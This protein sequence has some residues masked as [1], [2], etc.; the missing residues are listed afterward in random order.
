MG[1][2]SSY[3]RIRKGRLL[4]GCKHSQNH[5]GVVESPDAPMSN[6][7]K[8]GEVR[9]VR[10]QVNRLP[11][12]LACLVPVTTGEQ[13]ERQTGPGAGHLLVEVHGNPPGLHCRDE[14]LQ[15]KESKTKIAPGRRRAGIERNGF[16]ELY[17]RGFGL[18][19]EMENH[20]KVV[21]G[22]GIE[23]TEPDRF[24]KLPGRT[25]QVSLLEQPLSG[26]NM[27]EG[28]ILCGTNSRF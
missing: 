27:K 7:L 19:L 14:L 20:A 8:I 6:R 21:M 24:T 1:A 2:T 25:L 5:V 9:V 11:I 12:A 4:P 15:L 23:R 26:V 22:H 16:S 28:L 3:Q 13:A 18:P 10:I 17:E